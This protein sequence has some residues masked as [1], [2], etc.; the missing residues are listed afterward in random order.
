MCIDDFPDKTNFKKL[1]VHSLQPEHTW[2]KN[3]GRHKDYYQIHQ[4]F[5]ALA[6]GIFVIIFNVMV[7]E[8]FLSF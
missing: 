2:F 1:G 5:C 4:N 3:A 7:T 8:S 6:F